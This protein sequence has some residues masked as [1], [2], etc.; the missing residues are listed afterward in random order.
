MELQTSRVQ[1][2]DVEMFKHIYDQNVESVQ[3]CGK[4]VQIPKMIR[5]DG[6]REPDPRDT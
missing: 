1:K 3:T 2:P 5:N 6:K 4:N